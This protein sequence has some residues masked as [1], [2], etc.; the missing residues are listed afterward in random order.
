MLKTG[1][2][3][4]SLHG[5]L[6]DQAPAIGLRRSIVVSAAIV[7]TLA[8]ATATATTTFVA[9]HLTR[10]SGEDLQTRATALA[11][12]IDQR[13]R[14]YSA[15]L[16]TIAESYSLQEQLDLSIVEWEARRVGALFDGWFVL[17]RGGDVMD[18]MMSTTHAEGS[19]PPPQPRT[20][21]PEVMRAEAESIRT[22][23]PVVSDAFLGRLVPEL[24]ITVVKPVGTRSIPSGFM[25]FTVTLRGITSWLEETVLAEDEFAAIADG[26]R[27]VI[28]R[29]IDVERQG[30]VIQCLGRGFST[31]SLAPGL[32]YPLAP[33]TLAER[34]RLWKEPTTVLR[35]EFDSAPKG[36]LVV[37]TLAVEIEARRRPGCADLL[38]EGLVWTHFGA[39]RGINSFT[40]LQT[41]V[42]IGR[43]QPP[44][45]A[46]Q[47]IARAYFALDARPFDPAVSDYVVRRRT[48]CGKKGQASSTTIQTHPDPRV[49]RVLWQ[50]REAE[51]IQAIDRV[52]AVRFPRRILILNSLDLRRPDDEAGRPGLGVPADLH[53]SWPELRNGGNRAETVLSTTGGFLPV[54]PKALAHIAPKLFPSAEAA[55]KWL[56]RTDL[57]EALACHSEHLMRL[58]V[59]PAGQRGGAWPLLVDRRRFECPSAARVAFEAML[60]TDMAIWVGVDQ[61]GGG[62]GKISSAI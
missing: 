23:G 48:L 19:L 27:R 45:A 8:L 2:V 29:R 28:A 56:H 41:I 25:Y 60:G 52:R 11:R 21:Y 55:K 3:P 59:R 61:G 53:L 57:D 49:N 26:T 37:S 12:T 5:T 42:L 38:R 62:L 15:A 17:S 30:E 14:T 35:R 40:D 36:V 18:I 58:D 9:D 44:A 1:P 54:A 50:M 34:E 32:G 39:T 46:V 22:G 24:V 4:I 31:A 10:V 47:A 33:S 13:L 43:K 51:V 16:D 20:N 7:L 6:S